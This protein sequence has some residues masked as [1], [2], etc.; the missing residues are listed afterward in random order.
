MKDLSDKEQTH[1]DR[2][3]TSQQI[4]TRLEQFLEV[5]LIPEVTSDFLYFSPCHSGFLM[6]LLIFFHNHS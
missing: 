1:A 5:Q 3:R 2:S 6:V 4:Q